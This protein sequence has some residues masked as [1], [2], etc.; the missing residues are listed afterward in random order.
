MCPDTKLGVAEPL[1]D[2]V[3]LERLTRPVERA[4]LD[5][6]NNVLRE[7][8]SRQKERGCS[9]HDNDGI[10]SADSHE[11]LASSQSKLYHPEA[12]IRSDLAERGS[13]IAY[14]DKGD[15]DK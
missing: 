1:G 8:L 13:E 11:L 12:A 10:S 7:R 15:F 4:L 5:F 6:R 2:L 3:R 14:N 9:G